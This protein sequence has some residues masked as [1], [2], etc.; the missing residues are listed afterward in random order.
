MATSE[1]PVCCVRIVQNDPDLAT[2]TVGQH[3]FYSACL[4]A[5][6]PLQRCSRCTLKG[7]STATIPTA[8]STLCSAQL[9][10]T[11]AQPSS[12]TA[13]EPAPTAT[14]TAR[15]LS[16]KRRASTPSE[17]ALLRLYYNCVADTSSSHG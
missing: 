6:G 8:A 1:C 15:I 13:N 2:C 11:P 10:T 5:S 3:Y 7:V 9:D 17:G 12:R 16:S 14:P 4:T